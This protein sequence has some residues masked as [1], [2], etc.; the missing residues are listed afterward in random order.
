MRA[1]VRVRARARA[2]ARARVGARARVTMQ[3]G[4]S[5]SGS[6]TPVTQSTRFCSESGVT[7]G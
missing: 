1:K 5:S 6:C 3:H 4:A 2:R 7:L